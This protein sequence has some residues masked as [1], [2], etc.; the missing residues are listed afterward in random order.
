MDRPGPLPPLQTPPRR[1]VSPEAA[2]TPTRLRSSIT[3]PPTTRPRT[4]T[5]SLRR[6]PVSLARTALPSPTVRNP[7]PSSRGH[8]TPTHVPNDNFIL[9]TDVDENG[10]LLATITTFPRH[11]LKIMENWKEPLPLHI[12]TPDNISEYNRR[13]TADIQ[14]AQTNSSGAFTLVTKAPDSEAEFKMTV[15]EW[16]RAYPTYLRLIE[17]HCNRPSKRRIVR[18]LQQHYE[19]IV[20]QP[21]F[22]DEFLLYLRYDIQIRGFV[23]TQGYIPTGFEP[24]IFNSTL[25]KYNTDISKGVIENNS[26]SRRRSHSPSPRR[27]YRSHRPR[28]RSPSPRRNSRSYASSSR[29][30]RGRTFWPYS[31]SEPT[32]RTFCIVCGLLG[33]SGFTCTVPKAPYL[34]QDKTGRW[35]GPDNAQI[36]YKWN[37]NS[38]NCAGCA[39]EHR[40]TLCGQKGHNARKC[41]RVPS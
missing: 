10:H 2:R 40:C 21:D 8:T 11:A 36:C 3:E 34:V 29:Y 18:G 32:A 1:E 31:I 19:W 35:L 41:S 39:R 20:A 7:A 15:V 26:G 4:L 23:A 17:Y 28:S 22:Y 9:P 16:L 30:D 14:Y 13:P 38:S 5:P 37:N 33:H 6:T 12:L 24:N 25:R 27:N